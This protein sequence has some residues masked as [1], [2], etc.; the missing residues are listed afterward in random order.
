MLDLDLRVTVICVM[1]CHIGSFNHP[2]N[3]VL[4]FVHARTERARTDEKMRVL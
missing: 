2:N 3:E 4:M 1:Q